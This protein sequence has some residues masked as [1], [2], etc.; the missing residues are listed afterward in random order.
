MI[1]IFQIGALIFGT[2]CVLV[3]MSLAVFFSLNKKRKLARS[4]T[5]MLS[6]EMSMGLATI[7]FTTWDVLFDIPIPEWIAVTLRFVIFG[8]AAASSIHLSLCV[9]DVILKHDEESNDDVV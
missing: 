6:A 9:L 2:I 4:M 7:V 5:Y 1:Q 8:A 3:S